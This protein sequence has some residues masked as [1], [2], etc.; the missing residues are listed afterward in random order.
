MCYYNAVYDPLY[1]MLINSELCSRTRSKI[2]VGAQKKFKT[3][4]LEHYRK[5]ILSDTFRRWVMAL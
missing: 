1:N 5:D 3:E 2:R 4:V